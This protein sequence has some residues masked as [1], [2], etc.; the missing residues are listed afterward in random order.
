M[1]NGER[2]GDS[3]LKHVMTSLPPAPVIVI[4]ETNFKRAV[5]ELNHPWLVSFCYQSDGK[6]VLLYIYVLYVYAFVCICA[7]VDIKGTVPNHI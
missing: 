6:F 1:Y 4:F 5:A 3:L 2:D 7:L